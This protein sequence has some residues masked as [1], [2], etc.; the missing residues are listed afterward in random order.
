[1][2]DK[3]SI[4][5]LAAIAMGEP[6]LQSVNESSEVGRTLNALWTGTVAY[7]IE[8]YSWNFLEVRCELSRSA[9]SPA[10]GYQYFY[11]LPGDCERILTITQTGLEDDKDFRDWREESGLIATDAD[12]LYLRYVSSKKK[13]MPGAWSETFAQWVA[14]ELALRA[15]PKINAKA[16]D[17]IKLANKRLR[18][19]ARRNDAANNAARPLRAGTWSRAPIRGRSNLEQGR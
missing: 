2:A 19:E 18:S 5:N 15:C 13:E 3:H 8:A 14:S 16:A 11:E 9:T 1:M 17:T 12:T 10:W 7:C 6:P 4:F